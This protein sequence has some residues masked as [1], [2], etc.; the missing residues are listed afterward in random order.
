VDGEGAGTGNAV[1]E[2]EGAG[3]GYAADEGEGAGTGNADAEDEAV[4]SQAV[5][6]YTNKAL[7]ART[8]T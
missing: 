5:N 1:D 7:R 4:D 6:Q 3:T 2:G 8:H